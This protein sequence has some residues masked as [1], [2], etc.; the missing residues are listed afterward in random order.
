MTNQQL[1]QALS[2]LREAI[3]AQCTAYFAADLAQEGSF[4]TLAQSAVQGGKR[5][6]GLLALVGAACALAETDP[7]DPQTAADLLRCAAASPGLIQLAAALELYQ[8]SALVHDDFVDRADTRRG[9]PSTR[10]QFADLHLTDHLV[11]DAQHFGDAA[12]VLVGDFLL[13]SADLALAESALPDAYFRPVMRHFADMTAEVAYGQYLDLQISN[14]QL[15][16]SADTLLAAVQEVVKLKSA[17]YSVV[18]PAVLGAL[19]VGSSARLVEFL[20]SVLETAGVAFQLRDDELG[21]FGDPKITGKPA[22]GDVREGKRTALLAL[23]LRNA[24]PEQRATLQQFYRDPGPAGVAQ[25]SEIIAECGREPH[26][27]LIESL[28]AKAVSAAAAAPHPGQRELLGHVVY[29]LT[30]REA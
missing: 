8:A 26:E 3:D 21:V 1:V 27:Q 7:A 17:R 9:L 12:A 18:H 25:V 24:S 16:E 30:E 15:T 11:G 23:T 19:A 29:L 4:R 2:Q 14:S 13:S 20:A 10:I 5:F 28:S 22:G 6:R